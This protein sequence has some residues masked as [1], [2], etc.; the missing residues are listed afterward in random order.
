MSNYPSNW[1]LQD[2]LSSRKKMTKEEI[3][4]LPKEIQ[5]RLKL[6]EKAFR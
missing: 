4:Y 5:Y 2:S 3:E 6:I 1:E